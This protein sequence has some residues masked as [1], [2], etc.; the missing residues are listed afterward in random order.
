MNIK[1]IILSRLNDPDYYPLSIPEMLAQLEL[2][3]IDPIK[4][5]KA[6]CALEKEHRL[7]CSKKGKL[8]PLSASPIREGIFRCTARGFGFADVTE[9]DGSISTYFISGKDRG[10]A[11]HEDKV[12]LRILS[13]PKEGKEGDAKIERVLSHTL[14]EF[15]GVIGKK[16]FYNKKKKPQWILIPDDRRIEGE[17]EIDL[18]GS[19]SFRENDK[20]LA[21]VTAYPGPFCGLRGKV[22]RCFGKSNSKKA[23][24]ETI[25]Y[26]NGIPLKFPKEV[27]SCAESAS[28]AEILPDGRLDLRHDHPYG[29]IFTIDGEDAKDLDD[30]ISVCKK[31]N[32]N[33]LLGVHIADVSE[34][35]R[36]NTPCDKEAMARG[37]SVYFI[38]QVVPMLP[39]SLSNG[40]CSLHPGVDRY[41]LSALMEIDPDG[42][43]V[44]FECKESI[45][46]TKIRGVYSEVNDLLEKGKNSP[47]FEKYAILFPDAFPLLQ[48]LYTILDAK[49][50]RRGMLELETAEAKILLDENGYPKEILA[51]EIGTAQKMI[52][53][54]MLCANE[55]VATFCHKHSIPCVYRIHEVP[56]EE[57]LQSFALF[58]SQSG[59]KVA[60]L[61]LD[62][63][64]VTPNQMRSVLEQAKE[65]GVGAQISMVLLRSLS[66]A[67]YASSPSLHFGL[68]IQDYCHFTSPIRRYPDL[69]VHRILKSYLRSGLSEAERKR[70][71]GFSHK[72]AVCSSENELRTLTA[73]R[74]IEELYKILYLQPMIGKEFEGTVSGITAFGVFVRL[75]NT[76]EG[77]IPLSAFDDYAVFSESTC[78][79]QAGR[80]VYHLADRIRVRLTDA[81]LDTRKVTFYPAREV[82]K[83]KKA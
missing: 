72:S 51:R 42:N 65:K 6:I 21:S 1:E 11:I 82:R 74:Q 63:E 38:D 16:K 71:L 25:L 17:V 45:L 58:A 61:S 12:L 29:V 36:P 69:S 75:D 9:E 76:C 64:Q 59:L 78:S 55:A 35:V 44:G 33:Y 57:K 60:G 53:Q 43:L 52:E 56:P 19:L 32:G 5:E 13:L 80:T 27:L 49:S 62:P 31:G 7:A 47:Y 20:V 30:A 18:H 50:K 2:D 54:F 40:S 26:Q 48:E 83:E 73:E 15:T 79:L 4:G 66:K 37:C 14:T 8:L 46:Q 41:A 77:L 24:Y 39:P 23:N 22:I 68:G 67:K 28:Q 10:Y 3:G 81:D 70:F 34:Y